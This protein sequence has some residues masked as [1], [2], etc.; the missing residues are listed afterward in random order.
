LLESRYLDEATV[1][2]LAKLPATSAGPNLFRRLWELRAATGH[3][4]NAH[5]L[6]SL[7]RE[8]RLPDRDLTWGEW[9]RSQ[10]AD[11]EADVAEIESRWSAGARLATSDD[12]DAVAIAWLLTS[13]D[14]QLRDL[15]TRTLVRYGWVDPARLFSLTADMLPLDDPY[16]VERL[17][18]AS[19][20]AA[21]TRQWPESGGPFEPALRA[22]L[23]S[24]ID[25]FTGPA[26]GAPQDHQLIR[27]Y[28]IRLIEFTKS[29]H[30]NALPPRLESPVPAFSGL[31]PPKP[32]AITAPLAAEADAA[33]GMDFSN[34]VVGRLFADR[35]NYD[36]K[37]PGYVEG[38]AEIR[39]RIMT[40]G[41]RPEFKEIDNRV[42]EEQWRPQRFRRATERYG[43]KYSWIAYHELAGRLATPGVA[44][45]V[46]G[47]DIDPSFPALPQPVDISNLEEWVSSDPTPDVEWVVD[48]SS[49]QWPTWALLGE[50]AGEWL[51][52]EG[53]LRRQ[54]L[55]LGRSVFGF[56]RTVLVEPEQLM[57]LTQALA[58]PGTPV[59]S[60]PR[61]PESHRALSCEFP[62]RAALLHDAV[63][64]DDLPPYQVRVGR[65]GAR[66]PFPVELVG[67]TYSFESDG[68]ARPGAAGLDT[69]SVAVA[70]DLGLRQVPF[71]ID[72]TDSNG[73]LVAVARC[74]PE[75]FAG[76]LLYVRKHALRQYAR[77]RAVVQFAWGER[78]VDVDWRHVPDW[79]REARINGSNSWRTVQSVDL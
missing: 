24:L 30:P 2:E 23:T 8:S 78:E 41:W 15:A 67:H 1:G 43:K 74:A 48:A 33:L 10:A 47:S 36:F 65:W 75:G 39:G 17:L 58:L 19:Y 49:Q 16:V 76:H 32:I 38:M 31:P 62:W 61:C 54:R 56:H 6:D 55:D 51:L 44:G 50:T 72:L 11:I 57:V 5:Y 60:I 4:L 29:L 35:H 26:A 70:N 66:V 77:Q 42:R 40:L 68:H 21:C 79:Y 69:L 59:D 63:L 46:L 45:P 28:V 52:L 73:S 20:A 37:H 25:S 71:T 53:Y 64:E 22:F 13:T 27:S 7:L 18:L 12:L 3:R 14:T 9:V 34:Y